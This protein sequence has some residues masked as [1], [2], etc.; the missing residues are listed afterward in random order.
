M[1]RHKFYNL[2]AWKRIR[3]EQ[4]KREP[5]CRMCN[6]R[7]E[8]TPATVC[9]HIDPHRGDINKFLSGPFQS[10]CASCHSK[11]KQIIENGGTAPQVIGDDGWPA[12]GVD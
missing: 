7:G 11:D 4:L 3:A 6:D 2:A 8:I 10:L 1:P 12:G 5:L 9:D